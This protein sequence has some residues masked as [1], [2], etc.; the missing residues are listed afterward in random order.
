MA[1]NSVQRNAACPCGS[2]NKYKKCHGRGVSST[3]I[4]EIKRMLSAEERPV[5]WV[6]TNAATTSF[7]ADKQGRMLVFPTR[8]VARQIALLD[9]FTDQ[10]LNEIYVAPI[11][12][13][14]WLHV[15]NTMPFIDVPNLETGRALIA[16]RVAD[17]R[18]R[19]G[20][21]ELETAEVDTCN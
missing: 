1:Q 19:L 14:A 4:P 16:E 12:E 2:G 11:G 21:T 7:F 20:Y 8:D 13:N 18:A 17:Q 10:T 15:Q 5:R 9:L 6:I 3:I